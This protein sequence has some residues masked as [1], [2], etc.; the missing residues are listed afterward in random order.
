MAAGDFVDELVGL[1]VLGV[2][3]LEVHQDLCELAGTTGLLLV[4][5]FLVHDGLADRLAVC[6]LRVTDVALH[7]EFTTH[8]VDDDVELQL[9]HAGDQGLAG[10]FVGLHLEG[11]ILVGQLRQSD[12]H[13]LLV[14]LGLRLHGHLDHRIREGHGFE[15]D[16][17]LLVAQGITGGDVLQTHEGVDVAG[18]GSIHR[19]LLVGVHLEDLADA[20]LLALGG[21]KHGPSRIR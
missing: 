7:L 2:E 4:R 3:R 19:V 17:G 10:L 5:V 8:T 15:G 12:A 6:N 14:G 16:R 18:F 11:R 20:L 13:L 9:A 1:A 21:V